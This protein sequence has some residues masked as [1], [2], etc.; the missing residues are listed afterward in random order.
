MPFKKNNVP[1]NKGLKGIHL[2]PSTEFTSRRVKELWRDPE[3]REKTKASQTGEK[4]RRW[5]KEGDGYLNHR[6][7]RYFVKDNNAWKLRSR[8]V[9]EKHLGEPLGNDTVVHHIDEN[10]LNDSIENLQLC[11]R[12]E[13]IRIHS[14]HEKRSCHRSSV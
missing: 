6:L 13:H 9:M 14:P 10:P 12:E 11:T 5:K 1:W 2:C 3:Y 4:H 7:G 8:A